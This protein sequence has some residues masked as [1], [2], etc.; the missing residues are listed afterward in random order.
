MVCNTV[1]DE[2]DLFDGVDQ[3]DLIKCFQKSY[4]YHLIK[5]I[6]LQDRILNPIFFSIIN[7]SGPIAVC[8]KL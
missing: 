8:L 7:K 6:N 5:S 3:L 2:L 1:L 4:N